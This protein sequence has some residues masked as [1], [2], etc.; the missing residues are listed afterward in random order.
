MI[1]SYYALHLTLTR[2]SYLTTHLAPYCVL[3]LALPCP[4]YTLPCSAMC[5]ASLCHM[6]SFSTSSGTFLYFTV[7]CAL[8]LHDT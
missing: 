3:C 7:P 1:S 8:T 5:L 2:F 6:P 4:H